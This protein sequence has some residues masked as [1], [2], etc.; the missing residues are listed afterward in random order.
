[1]CQ[2]LLLLNCLYL[3]FESTISLQFDTICVWH[4]SFLSKSIYTVIYSWNA[5]NNLE[6]AAT[7]FDYH[8]TKLFLNLRKY[9]AE[10][11]YEL[12]NLQSNANDWIQSLKIFLI[13]SFL[14][15]TPIAM[16]PIW[17]FINPFLSYCNT[18]LTHFFSSGSTR[19]GLQ[20]LY[21]LSYV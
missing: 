16:T 20:G 19:C 9:S 7:I 18:F 5:L 6:L 17:V 15:F 4:Q 8:I 3:F 11:H 1:M 12:S 10:T 2:I 13:L 21:Y 14:I